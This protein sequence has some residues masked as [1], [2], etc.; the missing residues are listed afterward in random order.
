MTQVQS[1]EGGKSVPQEILV[2]RVESLE[3]TP[4]LFV[5]PQGR[6]DEMKRPKVEVV[7]H[8]LNE[9]REFLDGETVRPRVINISGVPGSGNSWLA[10]QLERVLELTSAQPVLTVRISPDKISDK[11]EPDINRKLR[12]KYPHLYA[13]TGIGNPYDLFAVAGKLAETAMP[14]LI[15]DLPAYKTFTPGEFQYLEN[16]IIT[17]WCQGTYNKFKRGTMVVVTGQNIPITDFDIRMNTTRYDLSLFDDSR[18]KDQLR[19]IKPGMES[20]AG[21]IYRYSAGLPEM[22]GKLASV[23]IKSSGAKEKVDPK[24]AIE[25]AFKGDFGTDF[26]NH[27]LKM[28]EGVVNPDQL[29]ALVAL[30]Q[31]T[32]HTLE[33]YKPDLGIPDLDKW[34]LSEPSVLL[35]WDTD[36]T[37]GGMR[38]PYPTGRILDNIWRLKYPDWWLI[39]HQ[40]AFNAQLS[41]ARRNGNVS[42]TDVFGA[43]WQYFLLSGHHVGHDVLKPMEERL[44]ELEQTLSEEAINM[45]TKASDRDP[46]YQDAKSDRI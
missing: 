20:Q 14:I 35:K 11:I 40:N 16:Q 5:Q 25:N 43:Y 8:I 13:I 9:Q 45:L 23:L 30:R 27:V 3:Y 4:Y 6:V 2:P 36:A 33:N 29:Y 19:R 39:G 17:P 46:E 1:I 24:A 28:Y 44:H 10:Q 34:Y 15:I 12:K 32:K 41:S 42:L 21:M 7:S 31:F 37:L 38:V 22:T 26:I 18:M